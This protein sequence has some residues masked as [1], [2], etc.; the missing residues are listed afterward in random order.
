M[1]RSMIILVFGL[2]SG[3]SAYG[4]QEITW[5]DL[6]GV[7]YAYTFSE[8][9]NAF[10][11]KAT[12]SQEVLALDGKKV[13]I[14]GYVLPLDLH[15]EMIVLSEHPFSSCFF[16]TGV[17]QESVIELRIK[18]KTRKLKQDE[19]MRFSGILKLN[20]TE[21]ELTYILEDAWPTK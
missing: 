1:I 17:G 5:E 20:R 16:C 19:V 4:Q 7:D 3:I 9:Q 11:S 8:E 15:G 21:F 14:E 6:S 2:A 10:S 12:F 13:T 18:R